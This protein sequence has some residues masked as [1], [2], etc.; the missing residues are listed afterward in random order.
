MPARHVTLGVFQGG[1]ADAL[2]PK[3]EPRFS[4]GVR[5]MAVF[6]W[7]NGSRGGGTFGGAEAAASKGGLL[8]GTITHEMM[9]K[10]ATRRVAES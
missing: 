8:P 2:A 6:T 4:V 7:T 9:L 10:R 1:N 3:I 5:R